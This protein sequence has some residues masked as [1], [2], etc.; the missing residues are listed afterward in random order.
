MSMDNTKKHILIV[1]QHGENRG[2][3]SAM[4]AMINGL[5]TAIGN[6]KFTVIVQF[7][8]TNLIIP[9]RED[10]T[11]LHKKMSY[12]TFLGLVIYS[13][14]HWLGVKLPFLLTERTRPIIV[15]YGQADMVVSA[16]GGPYFGDIYYG[17]EILHWF[18]VWLGYIYGKPL[19]LYAP[20]AGPFRIKLLNIVRRYL[21]SKFDVL[22]VREEISRDYLVDFL[23]QDIVVN[24]TADSA[25][26]QF[27]EP[28]QRDKYFKGERSTSIGEISGGGV[29]NRVQIPG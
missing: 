22:C 1:N 11:M 28:F 18:Y 27:I 23:G 12:V 4:R 21:F 17:H 8:D 13:I 6:V 25:I 9:F 24:V 10:V 19:F 2:D 29:C 15:A 14:F 3:E 26:Q 20:S 16:P 7:Q 5:E